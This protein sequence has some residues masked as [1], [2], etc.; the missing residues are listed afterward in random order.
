MAKGKVGAHFES[1]DQKDFAERVRLN[2]QKLTAQLKPHY[3]FIVCGSGQL[4]ASVR[5]AAL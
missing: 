3:D 4:F 1:D 5:R 2:Q